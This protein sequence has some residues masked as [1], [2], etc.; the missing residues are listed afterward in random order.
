MEK[1]KVRNKHNNKRE[2]ILKC[3]KGREQNKRRKRRGKKT[4]RKT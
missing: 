2:R 4:C 1:A 3:Y